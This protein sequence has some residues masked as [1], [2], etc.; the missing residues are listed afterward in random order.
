MDLANCKSVRINGFPTV[1]GNSLYFADFVDAIANAHTSLTS[2]DISYNRRLKTTLTTSNAITSSGILLLARAVLQTNVI[3]L[4]I[5]GNL[6][7]PDEEMTSLLEKLA[8]KL[9]VF[10][11]FNIGVL[12]RGERGFDFS[13]TPVTACEKVVLNK[14]VDY[15]TANSKIGKPIIDMKGEQ[16]Y[17]DHAIDHP[18]DV[19]TL[20]PA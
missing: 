16:A 9:E 19:S 14:I 8:L 11:S 3:S 15:L 10:N 12:R 7:V 2:I 20:F 4:Y 5:A 13:N 6:C 18:T 1:Q 17:K